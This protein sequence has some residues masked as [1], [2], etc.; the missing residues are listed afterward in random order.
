MSE[1]LLITRPK[2]D[3][4]TH[5]LFNWA[6]KVIELAHKKG[7]EVLDLKKERANKKELTS[8]ISKKHPYLIFFNGHGNML[9]FIKFEKYL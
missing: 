1:I 7:I 2:Y 4:T 9:L 8:I 5:Y 6:K 3:D